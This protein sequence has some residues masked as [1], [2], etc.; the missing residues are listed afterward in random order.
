MDSKDRRM[1]K[2]AKIVIDT[3]TM[4]LQDSRM[5]SRGSSVVE[6]TTMALQD[7]SIVC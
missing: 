4:I 6:I 5:L 3:T 2:G 7:H 1:F